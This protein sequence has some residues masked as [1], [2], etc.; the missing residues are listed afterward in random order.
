MPVAAHASAIVQLKRSR[1]GIVAVIATSKSNQASSALLGKMLPQRLKASWA[2]WACRRTIAHGQSR[3]LVNGSRARRDI[4]FSRYQ[5]LI[6]AA[7][8]REANRSASSFASYPSLLIPLQLPLAPVRNTTCRVPFQPQ[9]RHLAKRSEA[10]R[11]G[12]LL[13]A[14]R[15]RCRVQYARVRGSSAKLPVPRFAAFRSV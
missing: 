11:R 8:P 7:K 12:H 14:H 1:N 10:C 2:W 9:P 3:A 6:S 4:L 13:K 5:I 15:Y